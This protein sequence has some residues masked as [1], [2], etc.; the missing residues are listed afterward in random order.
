[1]RSHVG[2]DVQYAA[3]GPDEL[4]EHAEF[5]LRPFPVLVQ[6]FADRIVESRKRHGAVAARNRLDPVFARRANRHR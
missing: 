1:M 6:R 4:E 3:A 2:A 5:G